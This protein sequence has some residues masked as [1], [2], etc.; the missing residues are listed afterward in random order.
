M[1][2]RTMVSGRPATVAYINRDFTPA[3]KTNWE[4]AKVLFDDGEMVF[5]TNEPAPA[6]QPDT[7]AGA[8]K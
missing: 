5:L 7:T 1:I 4:L 2:E 6:P 8:R 3:D